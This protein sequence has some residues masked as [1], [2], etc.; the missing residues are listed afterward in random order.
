M[1][2][3]LIILI[4][5]LCII[6]EAFF[7]GTEIGIVSIDKHSLRHEAKRGK[8]SARLLLEMLKEPEWFLG[9]TLLGTNICTITSTTLSA[10]LF[11][12]WMG[13]PG[14]PVSIAVMAFLN[15][16]FAEIVP[17]SIFQ[18]L[19]DTLT[20][21]VAY[22]LRGF[23]IVTFPIV[24]LFSRVARLLATLLGGKQQASDMQF[25]SKEEL[26]L[27]MQMK[28]VRGDVKPSEKRMI[29]RLLSFTETQV[30]DIMVPL[31]D[32]A[33][34]GEKINVSEAARKFV[35][36]KHRRL[37]VYADRVDRIVGILNS[38]DVL[39]ED[40][41][42]RIKGLVRNAY[43][44]PPTMS[45][46]VLLEQLQSNGHNMAIVVDEF[47][48]AEGIVTIEDILEEVVGEI[49]DEYDRAKPLYEINPHDEILA[50][51]RMEIDELNEKLQLRIPEGEY[52]TIG[53][54]LIHRLKHIPRA[55]ESVTLPGLVITVRRATRRF[56]SEVVL[57][58]V[59]IE[60]EAIASRSDDT[61]PP[62]S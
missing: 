30:K 3:S 57:K 36:T 48:G 10:S 23:S 16:I 24:W 20:P 31:I 54:F 60:D 43:Y 22:F 18:Q 29:N 9:T 47:G 4:I 40:F 14:I 42:K 32:V 19:S 44:V 62:S 17:K 55:G 58:K 49:E 8:R 25:T 7:S 33:A 39:G 15:W 59:K 34:V 45:V 53:G 12:R 52:E 2:V 61:N 38:F 6:G 46:A 21:R 13:P 41:H 1:T 50:S 5:F 27:L 26:K 35:Q 51:G 37:P 11:Y 56:V 28:G